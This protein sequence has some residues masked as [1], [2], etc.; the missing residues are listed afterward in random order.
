MKKYVE[1]D[2]ANFIYSGKTGRDFPD[3]LGPKYLIFSATHVLKQEMCGCLMKKMPFIFG[4]NV[5]YL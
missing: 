5:P 3:T 4:K 1:S 2:K